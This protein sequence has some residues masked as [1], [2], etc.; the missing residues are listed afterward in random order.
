M[1]NMRRTR[2]KTVLLLTAVISLLSST[3]LFAQRDFERHEFSF[4]A[5][6]GNLLSTPPT[7]TLSTHDYKHELKHGISWDA[8][9]LF[10]PFKRFIFG[11]IYTGFSSKGSHA[12]GSDHL[13]VNFIGPQIGLSNANTQRWQVRGS[14]SPG[15]VIFRNNSEVFDK[16]RKVKAWSVGLL[17]NSNVNY[18][19]TSHLGIGI[20]VQCMLS[21]LVRTRVHYHDERTIVSLNSDTPSGL[22]RLNV[23]GGLSYYF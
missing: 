4:H 14:I 21:G 5:G 18:K 10:R 11:A 2:F 1:I 9:Y 3:P 6:Y 17:L 15:A 23:T 7:L 19:L 22:S 13:W 20:G 12:E 16:P 8:Q